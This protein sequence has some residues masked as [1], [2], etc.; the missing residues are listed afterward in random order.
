M[1]TG[2]RRTMIDQAVHMLRV[3]FINGRYRTG[4]IHTV[5]LYEDEW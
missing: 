3:N 5:L 2:Y 1:Y 4:I